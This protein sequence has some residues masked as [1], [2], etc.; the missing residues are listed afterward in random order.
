MQLF[1]N[2]NMANTFWNISDTF[3][4]P[5]LFFGSTS[6][7]IHRLGTVPFGIW[8]LIN[9]IVVSMQVFNFGIGSSVFRNVAFHE[10]QHNIQGKQEV[11]S[12]GISLTIVLSGISLLLAAIGAY[13]VY[14]HDLLHVEPAY[15]V[16]CCQG[17]LLAGFIVGFKFLEQVFTSYFKAREQFSK[18][19]LISSGNKM[20][21]LLLNIFLLVFFPLQIVHLLLVIIL[22]NILAA[23]VA[24]VL[25]RRDFPAFRFRFNLKL[26]RHEAQF[27]LF[28]WLQ[29]LAIL[30]TFQADRYFIVDFFGLAVLSYYAITATIFNH[31][32]MGFNAVLPWLAPKLTRLYARNAD[33]LELYTAARNLIAAGS[34]LSLL[35]MYLLYPFVFRLILGNTTLGHISEYVRYF[36]LFEMFFALNI[37]P[38]YYFNAMGQERKYFYVLLFFAFLTLGSMWGCLMVFRGPVAVIYGL[39][40]SCIIYILVQNILV[41]KITGAKQGIGHILLQLLPHILIGCFILLKDSLWRWITLPA[42]ILSLYLIYIRG[43]LP[44]FKLLFRS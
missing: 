32:H 28:T 29:S 18:A 39:T 19:M 4:Y 15:R 43:N 23:I 41:D 25:L 33:G 10:A 35:V 14:S 2:R 40:G 1:R 27:A 13:L 31:L 34:L 17:I 7:F 37:I 26:P 16:V 6:F 21:A 24:L 12:N 22:V 42:G 8:M 11:V 20:L 36:I 5:V 44:K 9:T 38:T 30:L 3:L